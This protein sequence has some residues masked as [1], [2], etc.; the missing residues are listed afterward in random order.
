[1]CKFC[2]IF[3]VN[4]QFS[5]LHRQMGR[6]R[7]RQNP[8]RTKRKGI[9]K[10]EA[11][12]ELKRKSSNFEFRISITM[13]TFNYIW[14]LLEPKTEY[15]NLINKCKELWDSFPIETQR[16]I[17]AKIRK[18]KSENLFVDYNP[19]LAIRNNAIAP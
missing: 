10:K 7:L 15:A 18:K 3:Y 12:K 16:A 8:F 19:L 4:Y 11:K 13:S 6:I 2:V 14:T 17:Y 1:M 9:R 5:I